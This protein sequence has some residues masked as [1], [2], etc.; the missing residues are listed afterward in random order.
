MWVE[1]R[2]GTGY[3]KKRIFEFKRFDCWLIKYVDGSYIKPHVDK[4]PSG[5]MYRCNFVLCKP[6]SGGIFYCA[7]YFKLGRLII[8]NASKHVHS[9]DKVKGTRLVLSVGVWLW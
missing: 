2:Q 1:G 9:C 3:F 4:V 5:N 8:F 6:V 7:Q